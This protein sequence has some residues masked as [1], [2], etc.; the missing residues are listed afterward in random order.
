MLEAR[1][2]RRG[3]SR[4]ELLLDALPIL[5]ADELH[6]LVLRHRFVRVEAAARA[7]V[8]DGLLHGPRR[9]EDD[10][11]RVEDHRVAH[12]AE[13]RRRVPRSLAAALHHRGDEERARKRFGDFPQLV[14]AARALDIERIRS[15]LAIALAA[16]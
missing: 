12:F 6:E 7:Q 15:G 11:R 9:S 3:F 14:I 4:V 5:E 8:R 1:A 13:L 2:R 10:A 16:L